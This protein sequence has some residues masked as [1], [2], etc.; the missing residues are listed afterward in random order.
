MLDEKGETVARFTT[1]QGEETEKQGAGMCRLPYGHYTLKEIV[2]PD[3]YK[4]SQKKE[5][6]ITFKDAAGWNYENGRSRCPGSWED[7]DDEDG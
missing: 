6:T 3:G 1:G 2:S 5:F 4:C 7:P